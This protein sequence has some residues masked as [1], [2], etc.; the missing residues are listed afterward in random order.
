MGDVGSGRGDAMTK[1]HAAGAAVALGF[2]MASF[3]PFEA[4]AKSG[5][6]GFGARP[7]HSIR[8]GFH[9]VRPAFSHRPLAHRSRNFGQVPW[10]GGGVVS[11]PYGT[12]GPMPDALRVGFVAPLEPPYA[13]S[14]QHSLETVKVPSEDGGTREIRITRC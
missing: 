14:C 7:F 1:M 12:P 8:P 4:A 9:S 13:L 2:V 11:A 10:Y 6:A 5:G 3:A